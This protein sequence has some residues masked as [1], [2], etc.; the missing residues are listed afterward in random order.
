MKIAVVAGDG[1]G[2]DVTGASTIVFG[3]WAISWWRGR[4]LPRARTLTLLSKPGCHLCDEAEAVILGVRSEIPFIYEKV[5]VSGNAELSSRYGL[6][7]P[8]VLMGGRKIFKHR[9][10]PGKLRRRLLGDSRGVSG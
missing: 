9:V 2:V 7:L 10:D 1:I 6:E 4:G 8:V 3:L 5:D